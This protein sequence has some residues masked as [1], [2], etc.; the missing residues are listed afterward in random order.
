M[1]LFHIIIV[2]IIVIIINEWINCYFFKP[3]VLKNKQR[4]I[5]KSIE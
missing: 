2:I 1:T 5:Q 4:Q 3:D